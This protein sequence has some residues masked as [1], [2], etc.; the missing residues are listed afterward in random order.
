MLPR[1]PPPNYQVQPIIGRKFRFIA[2]AAS[3][4]AVVIT[5]RCLLNLQ[6]SIP[7]SASV[8]NNVVTL[9]SSIVIKSVRMWGGAANNDQIGMSWL[10]TNAPDRTLTDIAVM[11]T[12]AKIGSRPPNNSRSAEWIN[13]T[14]TDL[15]TQILEFQF[16]SS[17]TLDIKVLM[18]YQDATCLPFN[19]RILPTLPATANY[20]YTPPLDNVTTGN[21]PPASSFLAAAFANAVLN[22]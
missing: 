6:V 20:F 11:D 22:P 3:T 15:D 12:P 4:S 7:R 14:D 16:S 1:A 2:V 19:G 9:L 17:A 13:T 8:N 10:G 5:R 21:I 18:I